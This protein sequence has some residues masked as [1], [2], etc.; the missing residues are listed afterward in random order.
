VEH[1]ERLRKI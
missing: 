1:P